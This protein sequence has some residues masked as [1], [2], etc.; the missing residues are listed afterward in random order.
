MT[1]GVIAALK[2]EAE[3]I[4]SSMDEIIEDKTPAFSFVSGKIG[5][6]SVVCS[7]CGVGKV[8]AAMC[9]E[10]MIL[11]YSPDYIINTGIAG[12]LTDKL[13][14]GDMAIAS[15]VCQHDFDTTA[16]GDDPGFIGD[17]DRVYMESDE[18]LVN[19]FFELAEKNGMRTLIGTVASGDQFISSSEK[20][21][22]IKKEFL[23]IAC[24]MEGGSIGQVCAANNVPFCVVRAISDDADGN[25]PDDYPEF[26]KK[27]AKRSAGLLI[28]FARSL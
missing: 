7:V 10:A 14:I 20:K 23:A 9:A 19:R 28:E 5:N 27:S 22:F 15:S 21:D 16:F 24:E 4:I 6:I 25:A 3:E 17:I 13:S 1:I 8:W 26:S 11:K 12:T 2:I 18:F